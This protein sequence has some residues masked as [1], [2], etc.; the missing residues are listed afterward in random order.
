VAAILFGLPRAIAFIGHWIPG[1]RRSLPVWELPGAAAL[2][3]SWS[4]L[5]GAL[6]SALLACLAVGI[7]VPLAVR[8]LSPRA[9]GVWVFLIALGIALSRGGG[10][11]LMAFHF[12]STLAFLAVAMLVMLAASAALLGLAAAVFLLTAAAGAAALI[13]EPS[14]FYRWQGAVALAAALAATW[15]WLWKLRSAP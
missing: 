4:V 10:P 1:E 6:W 15:V 5:S 12:I 9:L 3:P 8:I 11:A 7:L 13:Q 14:G 2:A